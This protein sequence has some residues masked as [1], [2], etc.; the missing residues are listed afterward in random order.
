MTVATAL[1]VSWKPLTKLEPERDEQRHEQEQE[2]Q[3]ARDLGAG[4]V[5]VRVDRVGDE[6]QCDRDDAAEDDCGGRIEGAA[7]IGPG[8]RRLERARQCNISHVVPTLF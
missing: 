6:Q 3:V 1:A 8:S 2:R 5:D 7:E 4:R